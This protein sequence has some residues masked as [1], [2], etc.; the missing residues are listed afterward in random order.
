MQLFLTLLFGFTVS[1]SAP[2]LTSPYVQPGAW[3]PET[4]DRLIIDVRDNRG[5]LIGTDG[6]YTSFPVGTGQRRT[7]RYI[8]K[9]YNAATPSARWTI[10]SLEYKQ[11]DRATY[12]NTGRFFRLEH[13]RWG[14]TQYGIH[15]TSNIADILAMNV[16]YASMGCI[17]VSDEI[18]TILEKTFA[19]NESALQVITTENVDIDAISMGT[20]EP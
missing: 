12:G 4:G 15:A 9:V 6:F 5:Y 20:V 2:V 18:L 8:G 13:E 10:R 1:A 3:I 17:L 11:G 19:L 16:R 14:R 7:V